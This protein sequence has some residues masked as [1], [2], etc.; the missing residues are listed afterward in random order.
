MFDA[1]AAGYLED[2]ENDEAAISASKIIGKGIYL[3]SGHKFPKTELQ[4]RLTQ[5][6][7]SVAVTFSDIQYHRHRPMPRLSE[8]GLSKRVREG[9]YM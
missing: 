4:K 2:H 6:G 1:Q 3:S 8:S 9:R 7:Q 5:Y